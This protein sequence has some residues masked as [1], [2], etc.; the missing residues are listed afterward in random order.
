VTSQSTTPYCWSNSHLN[1]VAAL[2]GGVAQASSKPAEISSRM[3]RLTRR[4]SSATSVPSPIVRA[5]QTAAKTRVRTVTD[6]NSPS[7]RIVR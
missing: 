1:T 5:T 3:L 7:V 6:Q 2:T 4:M